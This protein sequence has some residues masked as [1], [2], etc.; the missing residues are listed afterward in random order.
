MHFEHQI[1]EWLIGSNADE[2]GGR[3]DRRAPA[4]QADAVEPEVDRGRRDRPGDVRIPGPAEPCWRG[5][6][7]P[8]PTA[9][10]TCRGD[11]GSRSG[12]AYHPAAFPCQRP[13]LPR[14]RGRG[15]CGD[16]GAAPSRERGFRLAR[17]PPGAD[18]PPLPA[19]PPRQAEPS[20]VVVLAAPGQRGDRLPLV[21]LG[22]DGQS[23]SGE[24]PDTS[25]RPRRAAS[26]CKRA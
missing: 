9:S 17:E 15:P 10:R 1:Y 16:H 6:A 23:S 14:P 19:P 18:L 26:A 22:A 11:R 24:P 25:M 8:C 3:S 4:S 20:G 2:R 21:V 12:R 5:I 13:T 7:G